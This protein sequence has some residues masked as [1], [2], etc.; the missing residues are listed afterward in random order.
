M[1]Y[2]E[3]RKIT[4]NQ[5]KYALYNMIVALKMFP[6]LNTQEDNLRLKAAKIILEQG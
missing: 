6:V 1:T 4:G 5:S 3:A 2:E